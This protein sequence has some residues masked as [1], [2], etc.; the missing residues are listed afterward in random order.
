MKKRN[1]LIQPGVIWG[2]GDRS[3]S[4]GPKSRDELQDPT[5][6]WGAGMVWLV[7]HSPGT[8]LP[9]GARCGSISIWDMSQGELLHGKGAQV[10]E[11][12]GMESPCLEVSKQGL[13]VALSARGWGQGGVWAQGGLSG[14]GAFPSSV[15]PIPAWAG[16]AKLS[17]CPLCSPNL[18]TEPTTNN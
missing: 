8:Q 11:K 3:S 2:Q 1:F 10:L 6:R 5:Q 15:M 17:S 12:E 9:P 7:G 16:L 18:V 13:E 4:L 14:L